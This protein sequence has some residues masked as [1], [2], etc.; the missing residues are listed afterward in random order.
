MRLLISAYACAPNLGSDHGV[1]WNWATAAHRLG[2]EVWV[3]A[4]PVNRHA[5]AKACEQDRS[6]AGITWVYPEVPGWP[7][8]PGVE[9]KWERSYNLLWQLMA[10]GHA[11]KLQKQV[12]FD[13]VQ[14]LT[15]AGIRAPTFLGAIGAPLILGPVGG[16][17]TSPASLRDELGLRGRITEFIRDVSNATI[18]ANPIVAYGFHTAGVIFV[19]T[20]D[21]QAL[22][23]GR[24]REKTVVFSQ[25]CLSEM[26]QVPPRRWNDRPRVL[27]AGRL[28]YWKGA[29]IAVRAFAELAKL[30][31]DAR[32]TIVGDGP[33]KA[34]LLQET[35]THG[36]DDRVEFIPR[37]PQAELFNRFDGSDL[38]LFPSLHDSGGFVVLEALSRGVPVMCLDLGGPKDVVTPACGV[39][40]SSRNSS[41]PEVALQMA[42]EMAKLFGDRQRLVA[43][44]GAA[45]ARAEEF[46]TERRVARLYELAAEF[47]GAPGEKRSVSSAS[48]P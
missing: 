45:L 41:T 10:I 7:L 48:L 16:G 20:S 19:S 47:I 23:T 39:T 17:G 15:W 36:L 28:L 4:S 34:R 46:I 37:I 43:M 25:V 27:F 42:K 5:I 29:H 11:R 3:L 26:P 30:G 8:T 32:L 44:S 31:S 18:T 2:H 14:H 38:F 35:K 13:A 9:P 21:T 6:L 40:L 12:K 1:G 33:E 22:F 24:L